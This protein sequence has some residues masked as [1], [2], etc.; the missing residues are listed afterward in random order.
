MESYLEGRGFKMKKD[1]GQSSFKAFLDR[2]ETSDSPPSEQ[3]E[4]SEKDKV[5]EQIY[6]QEGCPIVEVVSVDGLP[7]SLLVHLPDGRLLEIECQ[8]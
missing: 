4:F 2:K 3:D 6:N 5:T 7:R 8:Y 1:E